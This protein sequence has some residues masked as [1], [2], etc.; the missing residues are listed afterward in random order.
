MKPHLARD[1]GKLKRYGG[2][3]LRAV[4]DDIWITFAGVNANICAACHT[5]PPDGRKV[6]SLDLDGTWLLHGEGPCNWQDTKEN[7][8]S[9]DI[10]PYPDCSDDDPP[11]VYELPFDLNVYLYRLESGLWA[12][13]ATGGITELG[14]NMIFFLKT[15]ICRG[16]FGEVQN[17]VLDT[18]WAVVDSFYTGATGGSAAIS[19]IEPT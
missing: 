14:F 6:K 1:A 3:L 19:L 15:G 2:K 17:S 4:P 18:C 7:G 13:K 11:Q 9:L 12:I 16:L 8:A 5:S 10:Y